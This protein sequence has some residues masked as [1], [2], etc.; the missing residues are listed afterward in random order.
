MDSL[1][2]Q[3]IKNLLGNNIWNTWFKKLKIFSDSSTIT[4]IAENEFIAGWIEK[5]YIQLL[6][7]IFTKEIII[8]ARQKENIIELSKELLTNDSHI[9]SNLTFANFIVGDANHLAYEISLKL[10]QEFKDKNFNFPFFIKGDSGVGKTHL[11]HAIGNALIQ[12]DTKVLY[13]TSETFLKNYL[14][15]L[16]SNAGSQGFNENLCRYDLLFLD[17]FQ[18]FVGKEQTQIQFLSIMNNIL[19]ARRGLIISSDQMPAEFTKLKK[20]TIDRLSTGMPVEIKR[21]DYALKC[22]LLKSWGLG[23]QIINIIANLNLSIREL[24]GAVNRI[25]L[26]AECSGR[27]I[28]ALFIQQ[29]LSELFVRRAKQPSFYDIQAAVL[30]YFSTITEEELLSAA[31]SKD[32]ALARHILIYLTI[33]Y[34]NIS[35]DKL[36]EMLNRERTTIYNSINKISKMLKNNSDICSQVEIIRSYF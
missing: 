17:D 32:I 34:S 15:S 30:K 6:S 14:H 16:K 7:K 29:T 33:Q 2:S 31:R 1:I 3:E 35:H 26:H 11:M 28:T 8:N 20:Q 23:P 19:K 24:K 25:Q 10:V 9:D 4:F 36:A 18:F 12:Q 21:P 13:I 22:N 27:S 5:N